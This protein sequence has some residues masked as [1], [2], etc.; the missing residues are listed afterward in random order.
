MV[1]NNY[2]VPEIDVRNNLKDIFSKG[3]VKSL[4]SNDTGI[5]YTLESLM[6]IAEN[7]NDG[8]DLKF[9]GK[10]YELK[11]HREGCNSLVTLFTKE[12]KKGLLKDV[13]MMRKYGYV[14]KEGRQALKV[15]LSSTS[16]VPQGL[17]LEVD[18]E[19]EKL[20]IVHKDDGVLWYYNFN[21]LME[22]LKNKY[23]YGLIFVSAKTKRLNDVEYFHYNQAVI[24]DTINEIQFMKLVEQGYVMVDLRMHTKE[25]G[26]ARN[27]GTG[28]RIMEDKIIHLFA[29]REIL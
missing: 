16:F 3:Y 18:E 27:H 25:N 22:R 20:N 28:F 4:R 26:I 10:L 14:D 24:S 17:K 29:N 19:E 2:N 8:P 6:G 11:S 12:P 13:K 21:T 7:N 9:E 5:G 1:F 15:T 23:Q